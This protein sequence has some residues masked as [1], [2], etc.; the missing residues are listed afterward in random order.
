MV[1]SKLLKEL[2]S[3]LFTRSEFLSLPIIDFPSVNSS[4]SDLEIFI[5]FKFLNPSIG[6]SVSCFTIT[7]F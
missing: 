1:S 5:S 3:L 6:S 4:S 2:A 7:F